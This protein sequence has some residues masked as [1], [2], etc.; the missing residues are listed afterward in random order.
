MLKSIYKNPIDPLSYPYCY[1]GYDYA[2]K[3]VKG[4]QPACKYVIGTCLR[5]LNDYQDCLKEDFKF[6]FDIDRAERFLRL[7][8][9]FKHVKG[10][11]KTDTIEYLPWQN[12]VFMNIIGFRHRDTGFPRF[13]VAHIE[14]PRGQGKS[15]LASQ[16]ALYFL[17]LDNPKGNEISCFAN[18]SDQARIV[19]DS[20]RA[21]ARSN[22]AFLQK[23]GAEVLAHKVVHNKS[24]S[25]IR[26]MSS[27]D[28]G[29]DGLNDVLA[30]CDELHVMSR[31]L[32]EVISSGMSKRRDSLL[33]AITTAGFS[34]DSVG[35]SQSQYAKK[36]SLGEVKDDQFFAVIYSID[37][38][39]DIFSETTWRKANPS[40]GESVDPETFRAKA[41]KA[42]VTP[43]DIPNFKV[44]HLNIWLSEAQAYFDMR[45]W[46]SLYDP[47][48]TY[49]S[50]LNQKCFVGIDLASKVDLS[51]CVS[52]FR[53]D[54][55]YYI[56]DRS[57]IP[58]Q[59]V[60]DARSVLYDECIAKNFLIKTPGQAINYPMIES[61]LYKTNK[62]H[63]VLAFHFDPWNAMQ[64]AQ[65]LQD[66]HLNMVEFRMNTANLSEATKMVD[67]LLREKKIRHNGSPLL[68]WCLGNVVCKEDANGNVFPR[69]NDER[70]K[71]D[72]A[73]ALI[74]AVAGWVQEK[75]SS[76]VYEERGILV[77]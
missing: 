42:K 57:Y 39:D 27:E 34:T 30:I 41:E 35:F 77:F 12:F 54:G 61:D 16:A 52:V 71:I 62:D 2:V 18:K 74:M 50:M 33:L 17:C 65:R 45:N 47:T 26:A 15:V 19:L 8:Q 66:S 69:K 20:A 7:V 56:L 25:V 59:T 43:S 38:G 28:K 37:E 75:D 76:S 1:E 67:A 63:R 14:V 31:E 6:I 55:I 44:K 24:N 58:E 68:K 9:K 23:T 32:F 46:D 73:V 11:W 40:Y 72:V 53:K 60:D 70:L 13:R 29:L 21:M 3:V 36:V 49:E 51:T 64:L 48:L 10:T 4:E 22:Q 5:F